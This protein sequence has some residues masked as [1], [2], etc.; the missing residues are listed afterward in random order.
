MV[1]P[2]VF[3]GP[4]SLSPQ[5][6]LAVATAMEM[7]KGE[8]AFDAFSRRSK[9]LIGSRDENRQNRHDHRGIS[10]VVISTL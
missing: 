5:P 4:A 7:E 6:E 8:F 3:M 2:C 1:S 10:Y 9:F